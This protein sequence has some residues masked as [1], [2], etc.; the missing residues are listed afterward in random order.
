MWKQPKLLSNTG[1]KSHYLH[2]TDVNYV[3]ER[4]VPGSTRL[5]LI[6]GQ[7][8]KF[9]WGSMPPDPPSLPRAL[10][11]D[12]YLPHTISFCPPLGQKA[13][14]NPDQ[15]SHQKSLVSCPAVHAP[16]R[17]TSGGLI[18]ISC[19]KGKHCQE[20]NYQTCSLA[21]LL[22]DWSCSLTFKQSAMFPYHRTISH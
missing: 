2:L 13:E 4:T 10:H 22:L 5:W 21:C 8:S 17:R 15:G 20:C 3:G 19:H 14:R 16:R 18:W 7:K 12:T 11:M 6:K 1:H 9:S